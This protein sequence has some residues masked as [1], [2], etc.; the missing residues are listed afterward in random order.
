MTKKAVSKVDTNARAKNAAAVADTL[1]QVIARKRTAASATTSCAPE[2]RSSIED[3]EDDKSSLFSHES[4]SVAGPPTDVE[5]PASDL[6]SANRQIA[7]MRKHT[8]VLIEQITDMRDV[9]EKLP[10]LSRVGGELTK[11]ATPSI[12]QDLIPKPAQRSTMCVDDLMVYMGIQDKHER[13]LETRTVARDI[14]SKA[15][16]DLSL[17]WGQQDTGRKTE[18]ALALFQNLSDTFNHRRNRILSL[19]AKDKKKGKEKEDKAGS[20]VTGTAKVDKRKRAFKTKKTP[21]QSSGQRQGTSDHCAET[22]DQRASVSSA[23]STVPKAQSSGPAV[24]DVPPPA[25]SSALAN[26]PTLAGEESIAS[27]L[28]ESPAPEPTVNAISKTSSE[29]PAL[30]RTRKALA[31]AKAVATAVVDPGPSDL[32]D[33][34]HNNKRK[35]GNKDKG[36]SKDAQPAKKRKTTKGEL[37]LVLFCVR[38][39]L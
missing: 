32:S 31:A 7:Q 5:E 38:S 28:R 3:D 34:S 20:S 33:K 16:F 23:T 25:V 24:S 4:E 19:A 13:W 12:R 27:T 30:P 15:G 11:P 17:S 36:G 6:A 10:G 9:M 8:K 18:A 35:Q 39:V 29:V 22:S 21:N 1:D 37:V 14:A 26:P 2:P